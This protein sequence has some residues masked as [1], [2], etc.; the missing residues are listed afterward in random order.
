MA[1]IFDRLLYQ[2][3]YL[4]LHCSSVC[5]FAH[6]YWIYTGLC[7]FLLTKSTIGCITA[8]KKGRWQSGSSGHTNLSPNGLAFLLEIIVI[9]KRIVTFSFYC[10]KCCDLLKFNY[11]CLVQERRQFC[12]QHSRDC[13]GIGISPS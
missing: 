8:S 13:G 10:I 11:C 6:K 7:T 12:Q 3:I 9:V 5:Q 2:F 1:L 4:L